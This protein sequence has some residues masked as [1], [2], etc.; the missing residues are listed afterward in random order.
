MRSLSAALLLLA[1]S[2]TL[3][4]PGSSR[5]LPRRAGASEKDSLQERIVAK[6][7]EELDALETGNMQAF[8]NL[9]AEEAVFVD[10]RGPVSKAEVVKN[11]AEFRL[12]EYAMQE[13]RFVPLSSKSGLIAYRLFEKGASHGREFA[14]TVYVSSLWAERN[15][16]W[17]CL[18]SQETAAK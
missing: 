12:S 9:L 17:L 7:R 3:L 8:A 15:G 2:A 1:L 4:P 11:T 10:A 18:F 13:V 16:K 6:E 14:G 5:A